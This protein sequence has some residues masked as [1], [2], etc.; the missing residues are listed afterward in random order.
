[1]RH[2]GGGATETRGQGTAATILEGR[3][4]VVDFAVGEGEGRLAQRWTVG[5]DRRHD[6]YSIVVMDPTATNFVTA[7]GAETDGALRLTGADDDPLMAR[8]GYEK[9][10]VYE[11]DL[12]DDGFSVPLY[13]VDTR[14]AEEPL[15]PYATYTFARKAG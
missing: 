15:L 10:F 8:M 13:Y 1:M 6:E 5:F 12:G 4:L 3:F 7:R 11:L 2:A 9:K 14:T